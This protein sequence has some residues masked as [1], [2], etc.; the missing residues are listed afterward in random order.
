[1]EHFKFSYS[2]SVIFFYCS[3]L[4]DTNGPI[5]IVDVMHVHLVNTDLF[6]GVRH[7]KHEGNVCVDFSDQ[8]WC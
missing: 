3:Q 7:S 8:L 5:E 6:A 2:Y 4:R 1:M